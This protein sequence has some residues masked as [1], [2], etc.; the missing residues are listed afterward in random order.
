LD[1][2]T[3]EQ[4]RWRQK[5]A[6]LLAY[7][8]GPYQEAFGTTSITIA[9][10]TTAGERRLLELLQWTEKEMAAAGESSQG[11]IFLFAYLPPSMTDSIELFGTRCWYQPFREEP[12]ALLEGSG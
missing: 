4:R 5:V 10:I 2:G 12:L 11:D 1:R 8:N 9:V 6:N 7:T 3:E